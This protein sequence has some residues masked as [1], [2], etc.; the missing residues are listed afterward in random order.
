MNSQ[1]RQCFHQ[2]S[3][4]LFFWSGLVWL[5]LQTEC[6][7][8]L[9]LTLTWEVPDTVAATAAAAECCSLLLSSPHMLLLFW[10]QEQPSFTAQL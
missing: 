2:G 8:P 10:L 4:S 9:L 1:R 7:S 3:W 5:L 6:H